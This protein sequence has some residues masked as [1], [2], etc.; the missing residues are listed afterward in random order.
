MQEID[1][2]N[3]NLIISRLKSALN[4]S[5]DLDLA[6]SLGVGANT[7]S[8]WKKRETFDYPLLFTFCESHSLSIDSIISG[9]KKILEISSLN[10]PQAEYVI[11][12]AR[13][14]LPLIPAGATAGYMAG[15]SQAFFEKDLIYYDIPEFNGKADFI[16][17]VEGISMQPK[18]LNGDLVACKRITDRTFIQW[19]RTHVVDTNQGPM[20]KRIKPSEE[21]GKLFLVSDN[22]DYAPILVNASEIR[23]LALVAGLIRSI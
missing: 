7:L 17:K 4:I 23:H 2:H 5:S 11:K 3:V 20:L 6:M 12:T 13:S 1:S 14:G 8:N 22:Q 10:E 18:Y 21:K 19:N 15:D 16:I 9:S